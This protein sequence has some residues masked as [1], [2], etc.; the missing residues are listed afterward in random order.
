MLDTKKNRPSCPETDQE[1][2]KVR[3][4]AKQEQSQTAK[5]LTTCQDT[6]LKA[7]FDHEKNHTTC[8]EKHQQLKKEKDQQ[9]E[10][11]TGACEAVKGTLKTC[12]ANNKALKAEH[13]RANLSPNTSK[14]TDIEAKC[15][16]SHW[17]YYNETNS[18][19]FYQ[20]LS[21][22]DRGELNTYL[23]ETAESNYLILSDV[24]AAN[25]YAQ[26][27]N[28]CRGS[29]FY[30]WCGL[31]WVNQVHKWTDGT[32]YDYSL[33]RPSPDD[34]TVF[35]AIYLMCND[36]SNVNTT[37]LVYYTINLRAAHG[38]YV[39]KKPAND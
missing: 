29:K 10:K 20:N 26:P 25:S 23:R 28:A 35:H 8:L 36:V 3:A 33:F 12:E 13:G 6:L 16:N 31:Q 30:A 22:N 9:I 34:A 2:E 5:L 38:R 24:K 18:C 15:E 1:L 17:T 4:N 32:P 39:C 27:D 11:V 14:S 37:Y 21:Y 7:N 19:Y